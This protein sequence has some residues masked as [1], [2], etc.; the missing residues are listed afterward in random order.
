[1]NQSLSNIREVKISSL[2]SPFNLL[3]WFIDDRYS[4]SSDNKFNE[5][6]KHFIPYSTDVN[7]KYDDNIK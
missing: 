6:E 5:I 7:E 1:M 4:S 2:S 3:F